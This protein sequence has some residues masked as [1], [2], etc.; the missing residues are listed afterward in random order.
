MP[1]AVVIGGGAVGLTIAGLLAR[2][3]CSVALV[4]RHALPPDPPGPEPEAR[5]LALTPASQTILQTCGAWQHLETNRIT[6]WTRMHV[7]E[8]A[9]QEGITFL[10]TDINEAQLGYIVE[11]TALVRALHQALEDADITWHC[12]DA[13]VDLEP[14]A[15]G[16]HLTVESGNEVDADVVIAADGADSTVRTL[17]GL[18]WHCHAHPEQAIIAEVE[19]EHADTHTAWQRFSEDGPIALLPLFNAHY[20]R[21]WSSARAEELIALDDAAFG[22][23]LTAALGGRTGTLKPCGPRR[24]FPLM[25]GFAPQWCADRVALAGDAAHVVHPLAGLGQN[26]G[27][28][29]A[30]VLQ[31]EMAAHPLS[32]RA[33]RAYE[34]RRKAPVRATQWLLE[35]FR[36]GFGSEGS[37]LRTLG[38]LALDLA[39]RTRML[40]RFF[41]H[42]ADG[43]MDGPEW[44]QDGARFRQRTD[45]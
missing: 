20:S 29:D 25:R 2:S 28:M 5:V 43:G 24:S 38:G 35:G 44:L 18:D 34:R 6:P 19:A 8:A 9:D 42:Q 12:P 17:A 31:E 45:G 32:P 7:W 30:A 40:R 13:V 41:I 37:G 23:A 39:G 16:V 15:S 1:E 10:A 14:Y 4:E 21:V 3:G 36:A 33:L 11:N 27:L 26:L 22:E